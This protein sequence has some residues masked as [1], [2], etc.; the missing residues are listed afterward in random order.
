MKIFINDIVKY[1][2]SLHD[3][4]M[5]E[6]AEVLKVEGD[7]VYTKDV[8]GS[9]MYIFNY[10]NGYCYNDNTTFGAKRTLKLK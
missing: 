1:T 5:E 7:K 4:V 10:K 8:N 3:L 6:S 9:G 2:F